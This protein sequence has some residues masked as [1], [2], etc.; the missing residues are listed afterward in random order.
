[1]TQFSFDAKAVLAWLRKLRAGGFDGPVRVGI[2]GPA[3]MTTLLK[4][5]Q[6]C[7]VR[8]SARGLARSAGLALQA[9]GR[10][11]PDDFVAE[12]AEGLAAENFGEVKA[13]LYSFGGVAATAQWARAA[14]DG[15]SA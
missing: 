1:V 5:A 8:A 13:H 9:L 14:E 11:T 10:A 3:S 6:R 15:R 12:L 2:A 7:G 4:F